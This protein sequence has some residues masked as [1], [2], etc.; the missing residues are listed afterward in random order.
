MKG[1]GQAIGINLGE[2]YSCVGVWR[3]G[4]VEIVANSQGNR[5][6]PSFVAFTDTQRL[7]GEAAKNQLR[8]NTSNTV[9]DVNRLIARSFYDV[10]LESDAKHWP[11]QTIEGPHGKA[12]IRVRYLG[13]HKDFSPEEILAMVLG[14]MKE[15]AEDYLGTT[16]KKA[17]ITVPA[18][19]NGSQRRATQDA[20]VLAGLNVMRIINEPTATAMA[21][22]QDG[23]WS[24]TQE[25]NVLI[26][27]LGGRTLDVSLVVIKESILEVK[28]S[29]RDTHLGGEDFTNRM[30][31]HFV[32]EFKK[33]N[34]RDISGDKRALRRLRDSC[35]SAKRKL[36][37]A[38]Q[39]DVMV[40]AL[41]EGID[42]Q[43]IINRALFEQLTKDLLGKCMATV[44]MCLMDAKM[45]R[46]KVD[47][48]VLVGGCGREIHAV[49]QILKW[50]FYEK[51]PCMEIR[52]DEAVAYGATV[53]AA[54]LTG[55]ILLHQM[56]VT[57]LSLGIEL[58]ETAIGINL[59]ETYSCVGVWRG[60]R[61][62]IVA[63][64]QGNRTTPSFVAFTDTERLV[65]E[66]AQNQLRRNTSN[67]VY[68]VN[69]LIAR[70]FYDV[71][72]ESYAKHWPFKTIKGPHG[73]AMIRVR[74]LGKH[75]DFSP[76]EILA[77]VL[78]KMKETAEDYLGTTIKKA[79]ITVPAYFN[80]SQRRATQDAGVLAGLNVM[81]IINE[82]TAAA[83]AYNQDG[84]WSNTQESNV[85]IYDLGGRTLDV[86]L[87]VIK[88]SILEVKASARDTHLGG[89]DF[90]NRMVDHFVREFKKKNQRDISGDKRALRRLRDSCE[91]AKRKLSS[92]TQADVMVDALFEGIDMQ[93]II[94]RALF[95]QLTKDLLGKCMA[96][97]EMC[98]MDAK[99]DRT[100]VDDVVLVGGCGREIHAVRQI[101]K[102]FF[103][104]K[105][106]CMEIRPDEAVAYGATVQAAILTGE[107]LLHQMEVTPLSLGIELHETG[108]NT[109]LTIRDDMGRCSMDEVENHK[110]K[111]V[112]E[113]HKKKPTEQ[114]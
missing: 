30:V 107:I 27:D 68:D 67:T 103:Y 15:T 73:K 61:V 106:P 112:D 19:F 4:R 25:S 65:G 102:W 9:Y 55:E 84:R 37:S 92:A 100:K 34:Q 39:A 33:K 24:N 52:P 54:I 5:T 10:S 104:E 17:V 29:A 63:N 96:T 23:R 101:L 32:R 60:G 47:D 59:S 110:Y 85:L 97:V 69:R 81:R 31:D 14:K 40:D 7:V 22:N 38:T 56:E 91:S 16:I 3:G 8:R 113:E 42:M 35:E 1:D 58:H 83:M 88:E 114:H 105:E 77:M 94:N 46:T 6:T 98:L 74:Y 71:S 18:Y 109:S 21:Y 108:Q 41:F 70:S 79:V 28:A 50:F 80:G 64:S 111:A 43:S 76:E 44:E 66:A 48:V 12:M 82:P 95:E 51:E 87:V 11:F 62:E 86:S 90:T 72:V 49:R 78:G 45:D 93:S 2:T 20:G 57:P 53:Q 36:S 89:E 13:K 26:Y 75:K 99:M